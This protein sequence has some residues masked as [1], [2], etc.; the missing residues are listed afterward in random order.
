MLTEKVKDNYKSVVNDHNFITDAL[1]RETINN[2]QKSAKLMVDAG[3]EKVCFQVYNSYQVALR[4]LFPSERRIYNRVFSDSLSAISDLYF[5]EL[6]RGA[7]IE[8]LNFAD[9]FANRSPS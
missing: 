6:C 8:L 2:L 4:I 3:F 5:S 1:P 9:S 7:I